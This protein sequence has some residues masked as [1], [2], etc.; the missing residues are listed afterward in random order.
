MDYLNE[1]G[2]SRLW[3]HIIAKLGDKVDKTE[4]NESVAQK[5]QVQIIT[6]EADD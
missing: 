4:F 6:W 2:L 5:T 1:N 3:A